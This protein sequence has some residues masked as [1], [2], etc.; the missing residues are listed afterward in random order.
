[1]CVGGCGGHAMPVLTCPSPMNASVRPIMG[2]SI[3]SAGPFI[4]KNFQQGKATCT[5]TYLRWVRDLYPGKQIIL[6]GDGAS[7]H[8]DTQVKA[9]LTELNDGLPEKD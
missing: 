5:V 6:L 4:S 9:L 1:M 7:Y 2:Q 3:C 8:R